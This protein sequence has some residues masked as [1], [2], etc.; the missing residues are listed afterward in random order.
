MV[1]MSST[2]TPPIPCEYRNPV[3]TTLYCIGSPAVGIV[4]MVYS[5]A[6]IAILAICDC[7]QSKGKEIKELSWM[8]L[9]GC[10]ELIPILGGLALII[11]HFKKSPTIPL[12]TSTPPESTPAGT[13]TPPEHN[14]LPAPE[15]LPAITFNGKIQQPLLWTSTKAQNKDCVT[16]LL[17]FHQAST[18]TRTF[19]DGQQ[20]ALKN[21]AAT[22]DLLAASDELPLWI[23]P[24]ATPKRFNNPKATAPILYT[25]GYPEVIATLRVQGQADLKERFLSILKCF[26]FTVSVS[27]KGSELTA[28][29]GKYE[30][31]E[32]PAWAETKKGLFFINCMLESLHLLGY[33]GLANPLKAAIDELARTTAKTASYRSF[34]DVL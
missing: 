5:I 7:C 9:K 8:L 2:G 23:F 30:N 33:P 3:I 19:S 24:T 25:D 11:H 16:E 10:V 20:Y 4:R 26:G 31:S 12:G 15:P 22:S 27:L 29:F 13:S 17:A 1:F 6:M 32:W 28:T 21:I 34:Y 14:K 18:K